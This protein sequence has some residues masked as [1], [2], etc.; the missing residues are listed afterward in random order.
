MGVTTLTTKLEAVNSMLALVG[1]RPINTL[2]NLNRAKPIAAVADLD[3][4]TK[5]IQTQGWWFN[6]FF[7]QDLAP[8][9]GKYII[10]EEWTSV[11]LSRQTHHLR[12]VVRDGFFF[13]MVDRT[14]EGFTDT[15]KI[16]YI[17][18]FEFESLPHTAREAISAEAA[19]RFAGSQKASKAIL[20]ELREN[21]RQSREPFEREELQNTDVNLFNMPEIN[22]V[23]REHG[24]HR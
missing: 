23:L 13:D 11:D 5:K 15:L 14:D 3:R 2:T 18:L 12:F 9:N 21:A 1:E 4:E 10:P 7:D 24:G 8:Q 17:E 22:R 16:N 6:R 20:T 19:V